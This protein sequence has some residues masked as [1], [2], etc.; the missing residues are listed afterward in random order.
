MRDSRDSGAAV[1]A[2]HPGRFGLLAALPT[3]DPDEVLA[4][5]GRPGTSCRDPDAMLVIAHCRG[6]ALPALFD[7][8]V[9]PGTKAWVPNQ[10][11]RTAEEMRAT[12]AGLYIDTAATGSAHTLARRR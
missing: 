1:V 9:L 10:N 11:C 7:R 8:L 3:D 12:L 4:E 6:G 5:I 2:R